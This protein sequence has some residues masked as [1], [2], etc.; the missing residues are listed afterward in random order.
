MMMF[1]LVLGTFLRP[2]KQ[3]DVIYSYTFNLMVLAAAL[4]TFSVFG[5]NFTRLADYYY[6]FV[7]LYIPLMLQS[8][9]SQAEEDPSR[10]Q[11]IRYVSGDAYFFLSIGVTAFALWYYF[12]LANSGNPLMAS[13]KFLW[14]IDAHAL[15]GA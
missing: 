2:V 1:I 15:Y 12:R 8:G 6:Q 5:N 10:A 3:S 14:Q 9:S 7:V 11:E 13:Y 4:Q